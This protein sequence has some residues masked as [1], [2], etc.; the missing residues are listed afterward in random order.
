MKMLNF[1]LIEIIVFLSNGNDRFLS[2]ENDRLLS[3]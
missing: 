2:N 1:Y 3:N